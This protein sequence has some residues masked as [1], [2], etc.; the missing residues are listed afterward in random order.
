MPT[1]VRTRGKAFF[2]VVGLLFAWSPKFILEIIKLKFGFLLS[3]IYFLVT[4]YKPRKIKKVRA[5]INKFK[6]PA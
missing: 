5:T 2:E 4:D 3:Q 1:L 6:K